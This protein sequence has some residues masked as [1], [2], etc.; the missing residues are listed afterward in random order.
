MR[1]RRDRKLSLYII[2]I[3]PFICTRK[4]IVVVQ[5]L[6]VQSIRDCLSLSGLRERDFNGTVTFRDDHTTL[7]D[8]SKMSLGI[9]RGRWVVL[10]QGSSHQHIRCYM[11]NAENGHIEVDGVP[12][13]I[14]DVSAMMKHIEYFLEHVRTEDLVTIPPTIVTPLPSAEL[15]AA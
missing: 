13:T 4:S 10:I 11:Y 3:S 15:V 6:T 7:P 8:G 12:G 9:E 5:S 2:D 14:G 1:S